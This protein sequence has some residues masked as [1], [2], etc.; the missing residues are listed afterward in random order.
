MPSIEA[1]PQPG[2]T[3]A[4]AVSSSSLWVTRIAV[5]IAGLV[6]LVALATSLATSLA[7]RNGYQTMTMVTGSM[8]P[9][10]AV[11]DLVISHQVSPVAIKVGDVITFREPVGDHLV[12]SHRVQS[13]TTGPLGPQFIT[14]GD[15]N[16]KPD[17]W[18]IHYTGPAWRV[19]NVIPYA[20]HVVAWMKGTTGR[21]ATWLSVFALVLA[22]FWPMIVGPARPA[23]AARLPV[24]PA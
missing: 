22:L 17:P 7:S 21:L 11:G 20:G 13:I 24:S 2:S 19:T 12:F 18:T 3:S 15:T 8:T 9:K 1:V 6:C 5:T 4:P 23:V 16:L 10:I 14:K